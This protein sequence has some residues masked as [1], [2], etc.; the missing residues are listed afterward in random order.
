MVS[1]QGSR[2]KRSPLAEG[3]GTSRGQVPL[4][5]R[6]TVSHDDAGQH[7]SDQPKSWQNEGHKDA[8]ALMAWLSRLSPNGE[9]H[10]NGQLGQLL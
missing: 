1:I 9:D 7:P 5:A 8:Q 3:G 4:M 2:Y 10:V 6:A